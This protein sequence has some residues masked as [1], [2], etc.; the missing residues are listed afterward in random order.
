M[1][2][3]KVA[4]ITIQQV[5]LPVKHY[6]TN[7]REMYHLK[8]AALTIL[9]VSLADKQDL[10]FRVIVKGVEIRPCTQTLKDHLQR[11][12]NPLLLYVHDIH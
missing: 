4:A 9:Q 7:K 6:Q 11:V 5:P 8:V 2:H 1:L 3:L 10:K 12:Y